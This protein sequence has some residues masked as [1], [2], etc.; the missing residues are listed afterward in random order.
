MAIC[1]KYH[2]ILTRLFSL[3]ERPS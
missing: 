1:D 2:I 3:L